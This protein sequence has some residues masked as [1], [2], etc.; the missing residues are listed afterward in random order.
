M[1]KL[2]NTITAN[3]NLTTLVATLLGSL[4]FLGAILLV[5]LELN[6][7]KNT[8]RYESR[9]KTREDKFESFINTAAELL[10][11]PDIIFTSEYIKRLTIEYFNLKIFTDTELDKILFDFVSLCRAKCTL[12][13]KESIDKIWNCNERI[14]SY[15][16]DALIDDGTNINELRFQTQEYIYSEIDSFKNENRLD[17]EYTIKQ[18]ETISTKMKKLLNSLSR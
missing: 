1:I 3:D 11:S 9:L 7:K 15:E 8:I 4:S 6:F 16:E 10:D 13:K 12:Y 18:L 5:I 2:I 14:H 17:T